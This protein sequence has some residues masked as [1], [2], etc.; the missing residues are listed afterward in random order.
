MVAPVGPG[1]LVG[2]DGVLAPYLWFGGLV[3]AGVGLAR[4][5]SR[6]VPS[7]ARVAV[8]RRSGWASAS[9][10]CRRRRHGAV[11][12]SGLG[13]APGPALDGARRGVRPHRSRI[14]GPP[15]RT[16]SRPSPTAAARIA[17]AFGA[18]V[19]S[20]RPRWTRAGR[21]AQSA[22]RTRRGAWS[23]GF[24]PEALPLNARVWMPEGD[25][26]FPLVLVVHGNHAMGAENEA[27]YGYLAEHLA[28]RGFITASIDES[29]LNGSWAGDYKGN[30][31]AVRAW[32]LLLHLDQWRSWNADPSGPLAGRVDL[33]RVALI[34]HSRGGEAASVAAMVADT[35]GSFNPALRPWPTGLAVHAVVSIAPSDGQYGPNVHLEG[36]DLLELT[37]GHDADALAWSGIRQYNR[38]T[39]GG[40]L[41]GRAVRVPGQ[42]RPV[43]HRLG[44]GGPGPVERR[45]PGPPAAAHRGGAAGRG[46]DG[47]R[48]VPRGEP[49]RCRGVP[50]F[51]PRPMVGRES[52]PD[53]V[54]LVRSDDGHEIAARRLAQGGRRRTGWS[55]S[56]RD[57]SR[58]ARRRCRCGRC[59][60]PRGAG[61][62]RSNGS[63]GRAGARGVSAAWPQPGI[64]PGSGAP[65]CASRSRTRRPGASMTARHPRRWTPSS[66]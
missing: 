24:G 10:S 58:P 18:D 32:L 25:G 61:R 1:R 8:P 29:F 51:L 42:P 63:P 55:R 60:T 65:R 53:D 22:G 50:R 64:P 36:V 62:R 26:P 52:L 31:Q 13:R 27:G 15:A 5:A 43:Q 6:R 12:R 66:R 19:R 38:T 41:Q 57:C 37:G 45:P 21:S 35:D 9:P 23:W 48:G 14:P 7:T 59:R 56:Q 46:A 2:P 3:G 11:L 4:T 16:R 34:G 28:S 54:Y 20:A 39:S 17:A 40:R 30:E 47:D 44:P 49:Q 33:G